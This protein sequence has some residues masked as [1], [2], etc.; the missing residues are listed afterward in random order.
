MATPDADKVPS[1]WAAHRRRAEVLRDRYPFAAEVLILYLA[2]LDVWEDGWDLARTDRPAP[3]QLAGWAAQWALPQ[4]VKATEAAGPE[5]LAAVA[6][7]LLDA[8]GV[9]ES[10][11]TW[12]AGGE[13]A[14][15][16]RYLA[17]ASLYAPLVALDVD[18]GA[19]CADDPSPRDSGRCPRCG[20]PPQ[21]SF[22]TDTEDRLVSGRR[23]LVCARCGQSW[24]YSG[25]SCPS[26][27]ETSGSRRT[28]YAE[29]RDGPVVGRDGDGH[30]TGPEDTAGPPVF[31]HLR[32]D[33]CTSC[34]RY[35]IDVDL[36]HDNRAVPDVDE[37][38]AL[39]LDL[40]A[41]EQGLHKITPNLM[42][43]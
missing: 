13:L 18:A 19:A 35:L 39:P 16:E 11:A 42:G 28:V 38:A 37:L 24:S 15:V 33:A 25:S 20:G 10:L 3:G 17:R 8:G 36:G 6:R 41:A 31:P 9:E 26:C 43:F 4:V 34:D 29:R 27:G 32:V 5:A 2:L 21:L 40:Y 7:D 12:L 14:P 22:R 1:P 23:H 30:E